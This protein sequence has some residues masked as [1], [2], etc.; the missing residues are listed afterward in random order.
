MTLRF[1]CCALLLLLPS[2]PALLCQKPSSL[3][4]ADRSAAQLSSDSGFA[5]AT[6]AAFNRSAILLWPAA[7]VV[8]GRAELEKFLRVRRMDSLRVTWQPLGVRLSKDSSLGTTWGIA[9]GSSRVTPA[10]PRLGRY[11]AVWGRAPDGWS[12][13]ALVVMGIESSGQF[14]GW[15]GLPLTRPPLQARGATGPFVSAD[16]AF[17]QLAAD[18]GGAVA[19]RAYAA[20]DAVSFGGGSILV[21]G[22]LAISQA[23]DGP[24]RWRWHPVAGGAAGDGGLGWTVGEAVI[25]GRD[26]QPNYSKYLTVWSLEA[27]RPARFLLDGG[28]ARPP[29]P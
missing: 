24:E 29:V 17:A 23:V 20:D 27:G 7:P 14:S 26:G 11:I 10:P 4:E 22:P 6:R 12:I 18:S 2:P 25:V 1:L 19:F 28:N 13:I 3:L 9:V 15:T 5:Y 16:I 8:S 21:Q